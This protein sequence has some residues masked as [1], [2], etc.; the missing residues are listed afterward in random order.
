MPKLGRETRLETRRACMLAG[1]QRDISDDIV[2]KPSRGY[3]ALVFR[4]FRDRWA[5]RKSY[6][7]KCSGTNWLKYCFE[8]QSSCQPSPLLFAHSSGLLGLG[9][10]DLR[11]QERRLSDH[12][13][14]P[15]RRST[16]LSRMR[17]TLLP[18]RS[19]PRDLCWESPRRKR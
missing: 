7:C 13:R 12:S 17:S 11:S 19:I 1:S 6:L 3:W 10:S 18:R 9:P 16:R 2:N 8:Q 5:T 4:L 14:F 15:A